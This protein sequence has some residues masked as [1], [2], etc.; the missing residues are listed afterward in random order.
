MKT[1]LIKN[2]PQLN[3]KQI[4][5]LFV[6]SLWM[7]ALFAFL[8]LGADGY[9][10]FDDSGT[11]IKFLKMKGAEG[12]MPLYSLFL[13]FNRIIWGSQIYL[14]VVV[15]EQVFIAIVCTVGFA[16]AIQRQ[17]QLSYWESYLVYFLTLIPF[18][19]DFPMAMVPQE[20][21]TEGL[22]YA[23]FYPFILLLLSAVW[24][25][26]FGRLAGAFGFL[27]ILALLRSQLQILF[28]VCGVVA[29]YIGWK[30]YSC[31][32]KY[33]YVIKTII[34]GCFCILIMGAG[35]VGVVRCN[36]TFQKIIFGE[37]SFAKYI[38][39]HMPDDFA[40]LQELEAGKSDEITLQEE[41]S[42]MAMQKDDGLSDTAATTISDVVVNPAT[43]FS[44]PNTAPEVV[45]FFESG[46]ATNTAS[47]SQYSTILFC[48][49]MYEA[50][51]EDYKLFADEK[52]QQ[53]FLY[54]Y[55]IV[56]DL[57][58][59]H[60]YAQPGLWEWQHIS[61]ALG[62]MGK[63]C[64]DGLN[65]YF[66]QYYNTT[67]VNFQYLCTSQAFQIIGMTMIKEHFASF[68][69]HTIQLMIP[70]FIFT[71]FFQKAEFYLLCHIITLFVYL[72][73]VGLTIW[74][75]C[76]KKTNHKCAEFMLLILVNNVI[77]VTAISL[78][79]IGLQRYLVYAFGIFYIAYFILLKQLWNIHGQA[80]FYKLK[81]KWIRNNK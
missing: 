16:L 42:D 45:A 25:R 49:G 77:M 78:V 18:T 74:C 15:I 72:S 7:I 36:T 52:M 43:N 60:A 44:A 19:T 79:F 37:G 5:G 62:G 53:Q 3:K 46:E 47:V 31:K 69:V 71:V 57:Q 76:S 56:D 10:L 21:L 81:Q 55:H 54:V 67:I 32:K 50:D 22:T 48:K 75:F 20:I 13:F 51:Y 9:V 39:S 41:K 8:F 61:N 59:R 2:M 23:L 11:Y 38:E 73:A 1:N 26:S 58:Y 68:L 64:Y 34:C 29:F 4:H 24:K 66:A 14:E 17:F 35:V 30:K 6:L 33:C 12:V 63:H 27:F 65:Q 70:S 80:W 28:A 40:E